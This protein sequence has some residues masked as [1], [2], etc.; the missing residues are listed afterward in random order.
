MYR[1][2]RAGPL[3]ALN[4]RDAL[5]LPGL[6]SLLRVPLAV[7]FAFVVDRPLAAFA[8]LVAAGSADV[9]DG[10]VARRYGL[11]TATGAAIDPIADKL[12]VA[13]VVITL[14]VH[15]ALSLD[16]VVL[17]SAREIAELPLVIWFLLRRHSGAGPIERP[18]AN[19]PGKI[20][21]VMQ[22]VTIS[23][24]L[25]Q[26]PGLFAWIGATGVAA[27]VAAITYWRRGFQIARSVGG[28]LHRACKPT[29]LDG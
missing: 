22:F 4:I 16:G 1:G 29:P 9:L 3:L 18:T 25:F 24:A 7:I 10:W 21:T 28:R 11:S 12:F 23:W 5:C 8:V 20:A 6:L 19:V 17:I 13:T 2:D 27:T 14:L 26:A 15:H